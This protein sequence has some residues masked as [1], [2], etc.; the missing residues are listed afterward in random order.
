MS[1][2]A[3]TRWRHRSADVVPLE[4]WDLEVRGQSLIEARQAPD[5][6]QRVAEAV[7]LLRGGRA[8][9]RTGEPLDARAAMFDAVWLGGGAATAAMAETLKALLPVHLSPLG[10]FAGERGGLAL[11]AAAGATAPLVVDV[12]QSAVKLSGAFGRAVVER[13]FVALPI[14]PDAFDA[15]SRAATRRFVADAIARTVTSA[16]DGIV[17][18]LPSR[19]DDA[20]LPEG[21]TYAGMAGDAR[22]VD[23]VLRG[24]GDGIATHVLNDAELAALSARAEAAFSP[25]ATVLVLTLG[26]SVGGALLLPDAHA[27]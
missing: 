27:W 16:P 19:L 12:G 11:L 25:R 15:A 8:C 2:T 26:F 13:D 7:A 4:L 21:S 3:S 24:V 5:F 20:L 9:R 14:A 22:F 10:R 17:L 18:A 1:V 6:R 23:E